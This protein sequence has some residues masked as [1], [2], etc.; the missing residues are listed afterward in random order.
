[1]RTQDTDGTGRKPYRAPS[2][3]G[4]TAQQLLADLG[5][6]RAMGYRFV[7]PVDQ[8]TA[9]SGGGSGTGFIKY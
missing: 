3:E 2:V 4:V 7:G 1:M 6:L 9:G 8:G 5:P